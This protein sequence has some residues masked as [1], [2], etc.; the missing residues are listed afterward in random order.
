MVFNT[1]GDINAPAVIL[2][3]GM[4]Q[5]WKCMYDRMNK[6][7]KNIIRSSREW[8]AFMKMTKILQRFLT[9]VDR[10]CKAKS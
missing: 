9:G 7:K 2:M 5:H 3:H 8:T 1:F 4:C 6:P 10:L